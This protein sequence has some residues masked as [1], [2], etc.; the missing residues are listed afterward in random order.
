M[1]AALG[2]P[3]GTG[4]GQ[5][6]YNTCAE[7]L[8]DQPAEATAVISTVSPSSPGA[9]ART[10]VTNLLP[11]RVYC[12]GV[13]AVDDAGNRTELDQAL[14]GG[15]S[16]TCHGERVI[17]L[18]TTLPGVA[19]PPEQ[20]VFD[21]TSPNESA[22]ST[23]FVVDT[24]TA[25][26]F[27]D[28]IESGDMD[29]DGRDDLVVSATGAG[30]VQIFLSSSPNLTQPSITIDA[31]T[32]E[33]GL[34]GFD[35]HL[36][37]FDN[38]NL[39]DLVISSPFAEGSAGA[40]A[41]AVYLYYGAS[42]T[43]IVQRTNVP[44]DPSI[45]SLIPDVAIFG[46]NAFDSFGLGRVRMGDIDGAPG[47][48]L[49]VGATATTGPGPGVYGF[50]GG[51]RSRFQTGP[52]FDP[53]KLTVDLANAGTGC[54]A[55]A[56][57]GLTV[58]GGYT[59]S[60]FPGAIAL[61]DV[62]GDGRM[63]VAMSDPKAVHQGQMGGAE[64]GEV[65][66][67]AGGALTGLIGP[68][69]TQ[70]GASPPE[71]L[72]VLRFASG[73]GNGDFGWKMFRAPAPRVASGDDADW[74]L[75]Q[76]QPG[77]SIPK[78]LIAFK[79]TE[80]SGIVPATYPVGGLPLVDYSIFDSFPWGADQSVL[81]NRIF[82]FGY[83]VAAI[84]EFDGHGGPDLVVS[85]NGRPGDPIQTGADTVFMFSY[86]PGS[87]MFEKRAILEGVLGYGGA[88]TALNNYAGGP[89]GTALQFVIPT[90]NGSGT[91]SGEARLHLYR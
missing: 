6:T 29:G 78:R 65:Y 42:G 56:N 10:S 75:V 55:C 24:T 1:V 4:P 58:V 63:D 61:A 76:A 7:V 5:V 17:P 79:G 30:T 84:G 18:L 15:G 68:P 73:T 31:P 49:I 9:V 71:L 81:S 80:G 23:A 89:P 3:Y 43:G 77:P 40:F 47:D 46:A 33:V 91:T 2:I 38:D 25:N 69:V 20:Q 52:A 26:F 37:D 54:V 74:L 45:P 19:P 28:I 35:L 50:Y 41:G 16:S 53:V 83:N 14:C 60:S 86:D 88:V 34:F 44:D 72:H 82:R 59:S 11:Q 36:G 48:D 62:N 57:F 87:D 13:V 22:I 32:S 21:P 85:S 64:L 70:A 27:G 66:V 12:F 39:D 51:D 67:Y 90:V 8:A